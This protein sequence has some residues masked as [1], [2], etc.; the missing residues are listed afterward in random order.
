MS[1]LT[2]AA[3]LQPCTLDLVEALLHVGDLGAAAATLDAF[4]R[5]ACRLD[6]PLAVALAH[7]G[8]GMLASGD[9]ADHEFEES[10]RC[11]VLEPSPFERARTQLAWGEHLRRRRDKGAAAERLESARSSFEAF[12]ADL[13]VTKADRELAANGKRLRPR[14]STDAGLTSQE[15]RITDLVVSGLSNRDVAAQMFLSVN[16]VETHLRHVYRKLGVST[17][18]QLAARIHGNP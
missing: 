17:R 15:R 16:T 4:E 14:Q 8:R 18:T 3:T 9:D 1:G 5:E 12:G 7:R 2:A 13:W 6:R 11:D 10:L